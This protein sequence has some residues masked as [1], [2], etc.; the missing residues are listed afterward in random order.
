MQF[1][2]YVL[3]MIEKLTEAGFKAYTVGGCVRD[4]LLGRE[5]ADWDITTSLCPKKRSA[6][7]VKRRSPSA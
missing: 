4:T 3:L 7:S 5:P 6:C 2:S 1:P